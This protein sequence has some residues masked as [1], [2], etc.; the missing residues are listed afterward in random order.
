MNSSAAIVSGLGAISAAGRDLPETL[1]DFAAGRRRAGPATLFDTPIRSPVF[2]VRA[3]DGT[4]NAAG[5][6]TL[7]LARSA[8]REALADAR[9]SALPARRT[10]VCL[11]TTVACQLN[12]IEFYT[13]LR[14]TGDAPMAAVD[15]FLAGNLAEA[16]A[17]EIGASGPCVTVAN[18]C[19]SGTDALGVALAWL[20]A[21]LCDIAIAGGADE[22]NRVPMSGFHSLSVMS[23]ELCRPFDRDRQGLNL[24]EGA[25]VL[26]RLSLFML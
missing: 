18:A 2:Q 3:L 15:H 14:R 24:G 10:G 19:S 21:G 20:Q 1:N 17:R 9:L 12:D 8:V 25:G 16:I 6:R 22:L 5:A 11:G 26:A 4:A 23:P 13:T 7:R